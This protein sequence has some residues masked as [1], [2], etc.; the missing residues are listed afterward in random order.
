MEPSKRRDDT[1]LFAVRSE[2]EGVWLVWTGALIASLEE[3]QE[4]AR[5]AQANDLEAAQLAALQAV[6]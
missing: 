1:G 6:S 3:R 4:R 2:D 5:E